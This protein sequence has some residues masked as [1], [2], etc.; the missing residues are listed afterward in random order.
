ME[1][2]DQLVLT[3]YSPEV[4]KFKGNRKYQRPTLPTNK[5]PSASMPPQ[6]R[7][8]HVDQTHI[9]IRM[10]CGSLCGFSLLML[11]CVSPLNW[12]QF[13]VIKNGLELYAGLWISCSHELCWSHTP[14]PPYYLQYSRAFY[15]ISVLTIL[16]SLGWLFSAC[17][18][19]RGSVTTNLDLKVS[20]L[21]FISAICLLLCL[22]LFLAQVHGHTRNAMESALLWAYHINWWSDFLYMFSGIISFVNYITFRS[23]PLDQNVTVIPTERSRLGIGPVTTVSPAEDE[24][25]RPDMEYASDREENLPNADLPDADLP[26]ADLPD[27]DLPNADL[28][29]ADLPDAEM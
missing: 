15:L 4:P 18:P 24:G 7:Q 5:H 2:R 21:S 28:P 3:F 10:F 13:L 27:T 8:Q 23:P 12:V 29:D 20:M 16:I 6:R 26:D 1:R 9:Y 19:R 14:K 22:I 17:L 25:S 11:I